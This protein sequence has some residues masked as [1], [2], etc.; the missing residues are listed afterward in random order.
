MVRLTYDRKP[1]EEQMAR[2]VVVVSAKRTPFGRY[3]GG[4]SRVDPLDL[5]A[6]AGREA[7]KQAQIAPGEI[8]DRV[9]VG[10]CFAASFDTASVV[11]RQISLK[12]GYTC[13]C[14]TLDTACCSPLT[15]LRL[16]RQGLSSG[17]F[18]A[19]LIIGVES[20][21]RVPHLV[22]GVRSGVKAGAVKMED[23]I[24]PI[25]YK[26]YAPVAI[27][28]EFG[29]DKLGITREEMDAWALASHRKWAGADQA[30]RFLDEIVPVSIPGR[31]GTLV[32]D[33]DEQPRPDTTLEGLAS[34][35]PIFGTSSITAG[36]APG[37]ND[38][39]VAMVVMT[40]EKAEALGLTPLAEIVACAGAAE[41]PD[42][43]SWVPARAIENALE[44]AGLC[45]DDLDLVEINEA[46]AAVPLVS[47]R[48]LAGDD[49]DRWDA[50]KAVTN[51]NGGA[52]AIGHP[53]GASGLRI[54]STLVYEL[55]RRGGGT[56]AAAICGGLAQGEGI[57]V[58]SCQ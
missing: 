51:V 43:M 57:V 22:R 2:N 30:G 39:A 34:L 37:L 55:R 6:E 38:G 33:R 50:L 8:I 53:V 54:L 12:L 52:V 46:F 28:A 24:F 16:A 21:S 23:P 11:G 48:I 9:F 13:F 25:E 4:L 41:S 1:E 31:R 45:V 10:N 40:A 3:L 56:G 47:T 35:K 36:N 49:D 26:G 32:V 18:E 7:I 44:Q 14:I 20:L 15:A 27:D 19:A 17:E 29:A 5:A 58:R 42:G